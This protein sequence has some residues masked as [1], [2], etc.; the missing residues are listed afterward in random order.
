MTVTFGTN[1]GQPPENVT[2]SIIACY[3]PAAATTIVTSG[4]APPSISGS[5][6]TLTIS[7]KSTG[8]TQ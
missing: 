1:N 6:P 8:V 2:L 4:A 3:T 5:T 7:S